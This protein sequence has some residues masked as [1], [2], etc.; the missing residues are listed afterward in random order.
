MSIS[1]DSQRELTYTGTSLWEELSVLLSIEI[2]V[3]FFLRNDQ[4]P[5]SGLTLLASKVFLI[6]VLYVELSDHI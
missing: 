4:G 2:T 3:Y 6:L 1:C 5:L